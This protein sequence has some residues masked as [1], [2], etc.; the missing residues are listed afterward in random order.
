MQHQQSHFNVNGNLPTFTNAPPSDHQPQ[1]SPFH[2][3]GHPSGTPPPNAFMGVVAPVHQPSMHASVSPFTPPLPSAFHPDVPP[4]RSPSVASG[5]HHE[6]QMQPA[7][8][9]DL[10]FDSLSSSS[11]SW[12]SG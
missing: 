10:H 3:P 12:S 2:G 8:S 11:P 1:P 4:N 7:D 5:E 6:L 9:G